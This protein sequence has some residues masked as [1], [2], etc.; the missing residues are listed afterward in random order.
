M[1]THFSKCHA[2]VCI[3]TYIFNF[4]CSGMHDCLPFDN[5]SYSF[6]SS[7]SFLKYDSMIHLHI[8][9]FGGKSTVSLYGNKT[10]HKKKEV[11]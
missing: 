11:L 9:M 5:V 3:R 7:S 8:L 6:V 4:F 1:I 2:H 10:Y